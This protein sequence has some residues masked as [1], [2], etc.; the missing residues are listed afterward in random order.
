MS[1]AKHTPRS[2]LSSVQRFALK[3]ILLGASGIFERKHNRTRVSL[4]RKGL[5]T[6]PAGGALTETGRALAKQALQA[7]ID[8]RAA[9]AKATEGGAA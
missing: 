3:E 9:I 7:E 8:R 5:L 2:R 6:A 4:F 1:A